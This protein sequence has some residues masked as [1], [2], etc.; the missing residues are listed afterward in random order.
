MPKTP[1]ENID[2]Q[3][4]YLHALG[5][6][7]AENA[8]GKLT[9]SF[10]PQYGSQVVEANIVLSALTSEL[11]LKCL[12]CI[13]TKLTPQG[14]HLGELFKQLTP[15]TQRSIIELWDTHIVPAREQM[16][17]LIENSQGT[18]LKRD[19]PSALFAASRTFEKLRYSYEG[20]LQDTTFYIGDLPRILRRIIL[21]MN[22]AWANMGRLVTAVGDIRPG[23]K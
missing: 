7:T 23:H 10:D 9:G 21:E 18:K 11:F 4:I 19:L 5:F 1:L 22:P 15:K 3:K 8:L 12:I 20:N 17:R 2:P 14:H 16:W 6:H 13:E